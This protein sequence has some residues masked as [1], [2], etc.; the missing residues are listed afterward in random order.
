MKQKT[1]CVREEEYGKAEAQFGV[2]YWGS[3]R[4]WCGRAVA[5]PLASYNHLGG[6][7]RIPTVRQWLP[8]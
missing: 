8:E 1:G 2:R 6:L 4:C 5:D 7:E 3:G